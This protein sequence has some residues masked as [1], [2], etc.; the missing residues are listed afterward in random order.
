MIAFQNDFSSL[1]FSSS[2]EDINISTDHDFLEVSVVNS[3]NVVLFSETMWAY[4]GVVNLVDVAAIIEDDFRNTLYSYRNFT[5]SASNGEESV[6]V[7]LDVLYCENVN[8]T[9]SD[10]SAF[11]K[12]NF[13]TT[14]QTRRIPP[15]FD[16]NLSL[17]SEIPRR[18][19]TVNV[20]YRVKGSE[21]VSYFN[22]T[23]TAWLQWNK[24]YKI[25]LSSEVMI[26]MIKT[27]VPAIANED[28]ELIAF[29]VTCDLR[30]AVFIIDRSLKNAPVFLFRNVFN[31]E[32]FV[33]FPAETKS[34]LDVNSSL[35]VLPGKS[36]LYDREVSKSFEVNTGPLSADE[37][38]FLEQ[39]VSSHQVFRLVPAGVLNG[40]Q[41]YVAKEILVTDSDVSYSDDD[42]VKSVKLTWRYADNRPPVLLDVPNRIFTDEFNKV[43]S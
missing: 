3:E 43:Y 6:S 29:N 13:L 42:S 19:F 15:V 37:A 26:N 11:T 30:Y 1:M 16:F 36:V 34:V 40:S 31:S 2:L 4:N 22:Y 24:N 9:V 35:A 5:V 32:D 27:A 7:T 18:D 23:L 33:S 14:L 39:L 12:N 10:I 25:T 8:L 20:S 41:Q 28:V 38:E 17:F 21:A